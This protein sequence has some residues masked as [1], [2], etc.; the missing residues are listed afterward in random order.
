MKYFIY[1]LAGL[2][3]LTGLTVASNIA[4]AKSKYGYNLAFDARY[5]NHLLASQEQSSHR[6]SFAF[7]QNYQSESWSTVLAAQTN[8]ESAFAANP[9]R[10]SSEASRLNSSQFVLRDLYLQYF[11]GPWFVRLGNQQVVWGEA[12]E[13]P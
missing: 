11:S 5:A 7:A 6:L 12:L 3:G 13:Q 9:S 8:S 10:Y 2:T 1:V 4:L